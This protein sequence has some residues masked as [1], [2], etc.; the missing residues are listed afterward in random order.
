MFVLILVEKSMTKYQ[1]ITQSRILIT[2]GA[3]FIGSNLCE[4]LLAQD[5]EVVCLDN[6]ATGKYANINHLLSNKK[7]TL[8]EG[9][10]CHV[11]DCQKALVGVDYVLHQAALGSVPRSIYD[12]IATTQVNVG[13]FVNILHASVQAKVKRFVYASSSSVYG[14]YPH[15]PKVEQ[16][17][18]NPLSPYAIS[19]YTNELYAQNFSELYGIQCIGLRYFNVYGKN[20]NPEGE[21]SAVIPRFISQLIR[22]QSPVINGDGKQSR[23]FTYIEDIVQANQLA[24]TT[25]NENALN[26]IYNI[27][28]NGQTTLIELY[29]TLIDLLVSLDSRIA[30]IQP[31]FGTE[32]KG[33]V[34]H[35]YASIEK[36]RQLLGYQPE[37]SIK[38]GLTKTI[39]WYWE[40]LK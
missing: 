29:H 14:D 17:I 25:K 23:D 7:F 33:D 26:Q 13:G 27:A 4:T 11:R 28:F 21:Y 8:I 24:L 16:H 10:I 5:N 40:N 31:T 18:G 38:D 1:H 19:K 2:G 9:D 36:A 39:Q 30:S 20:Q 15:L 32:R 12:P 22:H 37:Y 6:F 35:S 3:G 34:K